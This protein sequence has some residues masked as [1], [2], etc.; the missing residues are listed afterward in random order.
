MYEYLSQ[1]KSQSYVWSYII[2]VKCS[3]PHF[4]LEWRKST[5]TIV[6]RSRADRE[7]PQ[8][9]ASV[10]VH[11]LLWPTCNLMRKKLM[12]WY[13]IKIYRISYTP[14]I[15][16]AW[17]MIFSTAFGHAQLLAASRPVWRHRYGRLPVPN[18]EEINN[19]NHNEKL[20][21]QSSGVASCWWL[22][23][24]EVWILHR[25]PG[26]QPRGGLGAKPPEAEAMC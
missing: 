5:T 17:G 11:G 15:P 8:Y 19:H 25:G 2:N 12:I 22:G 26:A 1:P 9:F 6:I 14:W 24:K 3:P 13:T 7:C 10:T 16:T 18:V 4:T 20:E 21:H 23:V